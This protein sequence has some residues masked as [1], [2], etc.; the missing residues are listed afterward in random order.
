MNPTPIEADEQLRDARGVGSASTLDRAHLDLAASNLALSESL[1]A[2]AFLE[3]ILDSSPDCIKVLTYDG[4]VIYMNGNGRA[5]MEVDDF[6]AIRG[7]PWISFWEGEGKKAADAALAEARAGRIGNFQGVAATAKGTQKYWDVT[8]TRISGQKGHQDHILSISRDI[9]IAKEVEHHKDLLTRE[10]GHRIKNSLSIV[11]AIANQ[12]FR[13]T[14][15]V[16]L[17]EFNG[18]LTALGAAQT[19]LLQS[20]WECVSV[21]DMVMQTLA[22]ICPPDRLAVD[23]ADLDLDGRKGLSLGLALHELGTNALKFGALSNQTGRIEI[24]LVT[25]DDRFELTWRE[26]G[27]PPVSVPARTGFGTRLVTRNL[28]ADLNGSVELNFHPAGVVL[29]LSAPR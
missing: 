22:P 20:A 29:S 28:E 11:Q 1:E 25:Y 12:T 14:D 10:L 16:R 2:T 7:C 18:R 17:R 8:V 13:G 19:L 4:D 3:S 24:N 5:V 26:I 23:I 15:A 21:R 27:G 6:A 9:T